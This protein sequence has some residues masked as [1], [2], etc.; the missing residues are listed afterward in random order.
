MHEFKLVNSIEGTVQT[1]ILEEIR[2][3]KKNE[4]ETTRIEMVNIYMYYIRCHDE[5]MNV[6][7]DAKIMVFFIILKKIQNLQFQM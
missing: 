3:Q 6:V 2:N 7:F 5:Y 1:S 4:C